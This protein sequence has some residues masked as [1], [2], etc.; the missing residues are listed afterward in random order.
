MSLST[1]PYK[2]ARDFYPP[3]KRIQK[4]MFGVLRRVVES[5][6]YQEYDAPVLE[7]L[8]IYLAKSG[9]EIVNQQLYSF[10]DKGGRQVAIRPEMTPTVSRMVAGRRQELSYPLRWYSIPNLWRYER[11]Q[12]GRLREHWQLNVDLFGE[13][14]LAADNEIIQVADAILQAFGASPDTYVI[15]INSRKLV[16][17][18]LKEHLKL[19]D[20]QVYETS[21]LIDRWHKIERTEF[22]KQAEEI[23]GSEREYKEL[24]ELMESADLDSL[25]AEVRNHQSAK[26]LKE[27][28]SMLE[29]SGV[30]SAKFDFSV[31]R[32]MDY[33]GGIVF[34]VFDTNPENIRSMFGGGRYDGLVGLFGVE[35]VP[36]VGFGMGDVTLQRFLEVHKLLPDLH[37]ETDVTAVL[38]GDI[39]TRAQAPVGELRRI[40]VN[41]AVDATGRKL[42]A[43]IK[44]AVK[45]G[46][47]YALFIGEKEM[48]SGTYKL[49]DLQKGEEKELSLEQVASTLQARQPA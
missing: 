8:E 19:D 39:Y 11:P 5:F 30:K 18:F 17:Q 2:G 44:S 26:E 20:N 4:Y 10:E 31:I 37:P 16:D 34:E 1:Q 42:D 9:E 6:G 13:P 24:V 15:R 40:G 33:Y 14:G 23:M 38:I 45:S 7:P 27:L 47:R 49:R 43:Q 46:V 21:K 41:V 36:T 12:A 3:D 25:P 28:M 32:G 29:T 35:P 48:E 22:H